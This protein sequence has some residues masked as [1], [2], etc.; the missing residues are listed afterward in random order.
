[1]HVLGADFGNSDEGR[2]DEPLDANVTFTVGIGEAV[3]EGERF[4]D[5]LVVPTQ[6]LISVSFHRGSARNSRRIQPGH[7]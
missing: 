4:V 6:K 2:D 3:H 5:G 7:P 1:M